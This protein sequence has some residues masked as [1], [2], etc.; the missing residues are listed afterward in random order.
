MNLFFVGVR[1]A[2]TE[3]EATHNL[4]SVITNT[5]ASSQGVA[6]AALVKETL[7][8]SPKTFMLTDKGAVTKSVR[9]DALVRYIGK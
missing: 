2:R 5:S 4:L 6:V 8:S 3:F 1:A 9:V 7:V